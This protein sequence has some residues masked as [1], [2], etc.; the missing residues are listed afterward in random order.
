MKTDQCKLTFLLLLHPLMSFC[1]IAQ[2]MFTSR[3]FILQSKETT[4]LFIHVQ[5][6]GICWINAYLSSLTVLPW[7]S[8][9]W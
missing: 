8:R 2:V 1:N 9:F 6:S 4:D 5:L 3:T 7:V